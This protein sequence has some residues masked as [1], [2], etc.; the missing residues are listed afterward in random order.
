MFDDR[1]EKYKLAP[2][3]FKISKQ[4]PKGAKIDEEMFI[5][6]SA[7][8]IVK[9]F[10][11]DFKQGGAVSMA[12]GGDPLE[13]INQQQFTPDPAIDEDFFRQAVDSGN[14]TA[15]NPTKLFKVYGKVDAV[16]TPKKKIETDAPQGPPGTT[17]PATQQM[18]PSDFAFKSFT[19]D[20]IND[21]NAP[22]AAKPQDWMN[23]FKGKAAPEA[24]LRD[25]GLMRF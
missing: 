4:K 19:L 7:P 24:E 2:E 10:P 22:K 5:L 25:T 21:P 11:L 6:G 14:L 15:F 16:E 17:L 1:L 12:I 23:F 20:V 9:G 18:Q 13:N 3:L 8:Y